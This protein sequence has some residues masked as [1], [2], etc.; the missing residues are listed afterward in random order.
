MNSSSSRVESKPEVIATVAPASCVSSGSEAV[1][2]E[3]I[4]VAG[5]SV[6]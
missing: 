6:S 2:D 3:V 5:S 1:S 4:V